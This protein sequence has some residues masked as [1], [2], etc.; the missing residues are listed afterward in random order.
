ML[1][2]KSFFRRKNTKI[3]KW[4]F[5]VLLFVIISLYTVK[6]YCNNMEDEIRNRNSVLRVYSKNDIT[7][8]LEEISYI[9]EVNNLIIF[10]K[11][12]DND[13]IGMRDHIVVD[14]NTNKEISS[15]ESGKTYL[16]YWDDL[17]LI[18]RTE[19]MSYTTSEDLEKNEIYIIY[20]SETIDEE[21]II[22]KQISLKYNNKNY[23][24]T[25]KN[26]EYG[27]IANIV[28]SKEFFEEL[29][30]IK[31]ESNY[32]I[33]VNKYS[34]IDKLND[35]FA[36]SINNGDMLIDVANVFNGDESN[37]IDLVN[38][39]SDMSYSLVLIII[40]CFL[41]FI[42]IYIIMIYT[43]ACDELEHNKIY[44]L[45]GHS[46]R[47]IF[48]NTLVNIFMLIAVSFF[49]SCLVIILLHILIKA[50]FKIKLLAWN[51]AL[52]VLFFL[53]MLLIAS[54]ITII[55]YIQNKDIL[56]TKKEIK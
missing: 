15:Y 50:I 31:S 29:L 16:I 43:V 28:I 47:M 7:K 27:K 48:A 51:F 25:I 38:Y 11:G 3:C 2:Q 52:V 1:Y 44:K 56:N 20:P 37:D 39:Y 49:T 13:V 45:I 14:A 4:I 18:S 30:Q 17:T 46:N 12:E 10:K 8:D 42:I 9:S 36:D 26:I 24:M 35:K 40:C 53:A 54:I 55:T 5:T 6:T 21:E 22:G 32:L 23:E 34:D 41:L 33:K 19:I